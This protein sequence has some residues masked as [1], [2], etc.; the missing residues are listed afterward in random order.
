MLGLNKDRDR[1]L[2]LLPYNTK[3]CTQLPDYRGNEHS[4]G[5]GSFLYARCLA[6]YRKSETPTSFS[7]VAQP[8]KHTKVKELLHSRRGLLNP[9]SPPL[10]RFTHTQNPNSYKQ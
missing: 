3:S 10:L 4:P 8:Q 7:L 6:E 9:N 1:V 2:C 5:H